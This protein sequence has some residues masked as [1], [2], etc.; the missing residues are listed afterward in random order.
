MPRDLPPLNALRAFE[1][2]AQHLN[3]TKASEELFVTQGAVSRQ[4]K[5]L[6]Q[7]LGYPLFR[8]DGPKIELTPIG[9]AYRDA[10]VEGLSVI[11]RGTAKVRRQ[12]ARP[13]LTVSVL[14]SFATMWLVPRV[15]RFHAEHP[16]LELRLDCSYDV[17]DFH[18]A[19]DIDAAIRFGRGNWP[20]VH[21]DCLFSCEV[22]PVCSPALLGGNGPFRSK[23]EILDYPLIHA[24]E[25]M[26]DWE[27]WFAA[28]G[29]ELPRQG[30][31][32]RYSDFMALQQAA[33]EGQ[34]IALARG[35]LAEPDLRSG[36][37]I[38]PIDISIRSRSSYYFVCPPSM[39]DSDTVGTFYRW[40]KRESESTAAAC[41][42][43]D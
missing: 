5:R 18:R 20:G 42:D 27:R 41:P 31:T 25:P 33:I 17:V 22:F 7:D 24:T 43:D 23:H 32:T 12:S 8:R 35:L 40:L 28:A 29:L 3:F 38:R 26:D 36:R 34:G 1:S 13:T 15:A 10:V 21:A 2:A 9:A 39:Q 4:I 19:P 16:H 37:L 11:R 30:P 14:P 6:E